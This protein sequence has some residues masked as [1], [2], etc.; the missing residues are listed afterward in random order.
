ML[1][2]MMAH[3]VSGKIKQTKDKKQMQWNAQNQTLN[4]KLDVKLYPYI[5]TH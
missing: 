3:H 1:S 4:N 2:P 5:I